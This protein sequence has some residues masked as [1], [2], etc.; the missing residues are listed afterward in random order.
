[1][2]LEKFGFQTGDIVLPGIE[3]PVRLGSN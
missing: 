2:V 3:M 1:M